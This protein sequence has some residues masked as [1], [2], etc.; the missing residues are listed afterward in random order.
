MV[1][2][3]VSTLMTVI[4]LH[5]HHR[6]TY[7]G[8]PPSWFSR[9][10]LD[11]MARI[12]CLRSCRST[13]G[14]QSVP[15]ISFENAPVVREATNS[16]YNNRADCPPMEMNNVGM[17]R[18]GLCVGR[19]HRLQQT[20]DTIA[21]HLAKIVDRADSEDMDDELKYEWVRIAYVIDR[22]F[23]LI[24]SMT[25]IITTCGI[26]FQAPVFWTSE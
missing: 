22:F 15:R 24:F 1:L 10:V 7:A 21:A 2:V 5:I 9:L 18:D 26:I 13:H 23:M 14:A 19:R 17:K 25:T 8:R 11:Y 16:L 6:G 12:L 4:V 3:S 20:L